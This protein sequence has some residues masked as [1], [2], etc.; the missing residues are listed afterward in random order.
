MY[1]NRR[2]EH[3]PSPICQYK[4]IPRDLLHGSIT[5]SWWALAPHACI[6]W[7]S[8]W[9]TLF[10]GRGGK[11]HLKV[12]GL[13]LQTP[14]AVPLIFPWSWGDLRWVL[15]ASWCLQVKW[16]MRLR[17]NH[18]FHW[19]TII[20]PRPSVLLPTVSAPFMRCGRLGMALLRCTSSFWLSWGEWQIL[21]RC[22]RHSTWCCAPGV[23]CHGIEYSQ[24][25]VCQW[26]GTGVVV[27]MIFPCVHS[28]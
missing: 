10:W 23:G 24:R 19:W 25:N 17:F 15:T 27:V 28:A 13:I 18:G 1:E 6:T 12:H 14:W 5:A 3:P 2:P 16:C 9:L 22:D 8:G 4:R 7:V 20:R 26:C 21:G 11:M